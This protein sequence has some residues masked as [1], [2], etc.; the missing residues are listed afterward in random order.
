MFWVWFLMGGDKGGI[1][2][3]V[4][5]WVAIVLGFAGLIVG[6]AVMLRNRR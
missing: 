1:V 3:Y 2:A 6:I 4:I 5:S